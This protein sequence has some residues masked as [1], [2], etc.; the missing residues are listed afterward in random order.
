MLISILVIIYLVYYFADLANNTVDVFWPFF[1]VKPLTDIGGP[2]PSD[3]RTIY[4]D[5]YRH[6]HEY[7]VRINGNI[8][9]SGKENPQALETWKHE[10]SLLLNSKHATNFYLD[11]QWVNRHQNKFPQHN[12]VG[13]R[14]GHILTRFDSLDWNGV[15]LRT[16][17]LKWFLKLLSTRS[18]HERRSSCSA[19]TVPFNT[20]DEAMAIDLMRW[21]LR[22]PF[23]YTDCNTPSDFHLPSHLIETFYLYLPIAPSTSFGRN[24]NTSDGSI[25]LID[26]TLISQAHEETIRRYLSFSN[27][28]QMVS[29]RHCISYPFSNQ[30]RTE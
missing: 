17:P 23:M 29:P 30:I 20:T 22:Q 28:T 21:L 4:E 27:P 5:W 3:K 7:W 8:C 19:F 24:Q 2:S 11:C 14:S 18:L 12:I 13:V 15:F 10:S 16:L 1:W 26:F 25:P 6:P 9:N